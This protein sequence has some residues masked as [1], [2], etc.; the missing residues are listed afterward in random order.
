MRSHDPPKPTGS[1][2]R[3]SVEAPAQQPGLLE[4]A[5]SFESRAVI[6]MG[7]V[8]TASGGLVANEDTPKQK[9]AVLLVEDDAADVAIVE[10]LLKRAEI[11]SFSIQSAPNVEV[12]LRYLAQSAYDV[13]LV[14]Y[15]LPGRDGLDFVRMAQRRGF[16]MPMILVSGVADQDLSVE[17]AE[18]GVAD[19]I[20]KEE[21]DTGRLERSLRFAVARRQI[22]DR[23]THLSQFDDLTGLANRTL[24]N[25]RLERALASARRHK[26]MVGILMLDLDGFKAVNDR[27]GHPAG[28][29]LLQEVA[30]RLTNRLRESDTVGRIGGDE[31][32]ILIEDLKQAE[33]AGT[34]AAKILEAVTEP[35]SIANEEISISASIGISIYPHDGDAGAPLLQLADAAMYRAKSEGGNAL[36]F[37][38]NALGDVSAGVTVMKSEFKT[39]FENGAFRIGFRPQLTMRDNEVGVGVSLLWDHP[40]HGRLDAIRLRRLADESGI[41]E[42][43]TDWMIEETC[44]C[45][46]KWQADGIDN[47]H[48]ALPLLSRRQLSWKRVAS[49]A[50]DR[51]LRHALDPSSIELEILEE[52]IAE[53]LDAGGRV[54]SALNELGLRLAIDN[55][56]GGGAPA[57]ILR[58]ANVDTVRFSPSILPTLPG[59]TRGAIFLNTM[60]SSAKSLNLRVVVVG[61]QNHEQLMVVRETMCDALEGVFGSPI[62]NAPERCI[63]WLTAAKS[64]PAPQLDPPLRP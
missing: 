56:A 25:D 28:D 19:F 38:D 32:A 37:N 63:K 39:A 57:T 35:V 11:S 55:F 10:D 40:E 53:E 58:D 13:C 27:L 42:A 8:Y 3:S 34:V 17:A 29:R 54:L 31:F 24:L 23:I 47:I 44:Q 48:V 60:I 4:D 26:T 21:W 6:P 15:C 46:L 14:D 22:A 1:T 36:G 62:L 50:T 30:A 51:L 18:L 33:N 64:G 16:S 49:R 45:L 59:P 43:V 5:G 7:Q 52:H 9:I 2:D 12:G 61:I 41:L 20:D